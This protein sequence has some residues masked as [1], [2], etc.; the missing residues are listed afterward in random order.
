MK[1]YLVVL[2][3]CF[4]LLSMRCGVP[5]GSGDLSGANPGTY[6]RSA[7][8]A[9]AST[10]SFSDASLNAAGLDL[11]KPGF[12]RYYLGST[13]VFNA[14][15]P[16]NGIKSV[17]SAAYE[18]NGE[19]TGIMAGNM[20]G[21][22]YTPALDF[23]EFISLCRAT[24]AEPVV[25]LPIY[26]A[27][28][29]TPGPKM[30]RAQLYDAHRAFVTYANITKGYAVKYW[31][32]GNE[33]DLGPDYT[34]AVTYAE[35]FNE[36]VPLL[37][38][39]DPSIECGANTFWDTDRW[40]AL[41]PLIKD[42]MGFAVIHQYSAFKTYENF[43][44]KDMTTLI[45]GDGRAQL[46]IDHFNE[47]YASLSVNKRPKTDKVIVTEM[48]S[49]CTSEP[50]NVKN[51]SIWKGLHNI[52]LILDTASRPNVIGT[53][54]WVTWYNGGLDKTFNIF[55]DSNEDTLTPVGLSL[56]VV[57]GH[58]YP[59]VERK[60]KPDGENIEITVSRTADRSKTS[61]FILNKTKTAKNILLLVP[62]LMGGVTSWSKSVYKATDTDEWSQNV[63]YTDYPDQV[64]FDAQVGETVE[65]PPLSYTVYDCGTKAK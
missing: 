18:R 36:L 45:G 55:T 9:G 59:E 58:L 64:S 60:I 10:S 34:D 54:N 63:V 41:L 43:L 20:T 40:K 15:N 13:I 53:M 6:E 35:V 7:H 19:L 26:A 8:F 56:A 11:V 61:I 31:E 22:T 47:A 52:Q 46:F 57:N 44:A 3:L 12:M 48:S 27:Y 62:S 51:N 25:L 33:D 2:V 65:L 16:P 42:T 14:G 37:K 49:H 17:S 4:S 23:D 21:A 28:E 38:K 50:A 30:T 39:I 32:I 24:G 5:S 29:K 1:K